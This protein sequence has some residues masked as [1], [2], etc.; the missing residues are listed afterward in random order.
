MICAICTRPLRNG[1]MASRFVIQGPE[2][3]QE[4]VAHAR[5]LSL[6]EERNRGSKK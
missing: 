1:E 3:E 5:C 6:Y 4:H 2:G